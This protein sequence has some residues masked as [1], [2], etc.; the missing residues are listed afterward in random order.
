MQELT[1]LLHELE[2]L[3]ALGIDPDI[4]MF[5]SGACNTPS[6]SVAE[7]ARAATTAEPREMVGRGRHRHRRQRGR[8]R[9]AHD[10]PRFDEL[11]VGEL[12]SFM[13]GVECDAATALAARDWAV[14]AA[15]GDV[16]GVDV[17]TM[18]DLQALL[19][20]DDIMGAWDDGGVQGSSSYEDDSS[21]EDDGAPFFEDFSSV[22]RKYRK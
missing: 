6:A 8:Q 11:T 3:R 12:L 1:L 21:D 9:L 22:N 16:R 2:G 4:T 5:D 20:L 13:S 18:A 19:L 15:A 10:L 7:A 17:R 14:R